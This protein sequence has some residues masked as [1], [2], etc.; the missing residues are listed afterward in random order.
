MTWRL[1]T[2]CT[3]LLSLVTAC[4][5]QT[6]ESGQRPGAVTPT[7]STPS[8]NQSDTYRDPGGTFA[9][10]YPAGWHITYSDRNNDAHAVTITNLAPGTE[11]EPRG[12]ADSD[13]R[14]DVALTASDSIPKS[15]PDDRSSI[16]GTNVSGTY[17]L[18]TEDEL[19]AQEGYDAR[20]GVKLAGNVVFPLGKPIDRFDTLIV[21]LRA[22]SDSDSVRSTFLALAKSIEVTL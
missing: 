9:F 21:T 11:E 5:T 10:A 18:L 2:L 13:I 14:I 20:G 19:K 17:D 16:N 15:S 4:A 7:E 1:S 8:P 22:G 12:F 3:V 6:T